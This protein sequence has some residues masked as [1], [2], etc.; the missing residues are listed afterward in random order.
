MCSCSSILEALSDWMDLGSVFI[1]E[2]R[3]RPGLGGG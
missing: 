1:P 3:P 2:Q